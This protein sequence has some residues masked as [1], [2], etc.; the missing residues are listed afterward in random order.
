MLRIMSNNI[1]RCDENNEIW[2]SFG[3]DCSAEARVPGLFRVYRE[4]EPDV[5]GLQEC[6]PHMADLL[7]RLFSKQK[8]PYALLWG[9]DTPIIYRTDKFEVSHTEFLIYPEEI[10]GHDGSFNNQQTKSYC[11]AVFREKESG[12]QLIFATTHLWWKSSDPANKNYQPYSDEARA[13]QLNLLM[14]RLDELEKVYACPI[15]F[16]GDLNATPDSLAVQAAFARGYRHAYDLA[17]E[18]RNET[19]G[20]HYC[21]PDRY[22]TEPYPLQ[23]DQSIDH[24]LLRGEEEG[25]VRRFDRYA[26]DYYMPFSDHFPVWIDMEL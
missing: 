25:C 20:M 22:D 4:T 7:M 10:E 8:L 5:I 3:A 12:K 21:Y 24:I 14:D 26:P 11:I 18:Y 9:K 19:Q 23:F 15:I 6:S 1:W 16:V 17:V 2:R 13:V